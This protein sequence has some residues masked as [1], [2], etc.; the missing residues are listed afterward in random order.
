LGRS[1]T[2]NR[3]NYFI[4]R[5]YPICRCRNKQQGTSTTNFLSSCLGLAWFNPI[6]TTQGFSES[7]LN[8]SMLN[9]FE[10]IEATHQSVL[11]L[12]DSISVLLSTNNQSMI[13]LYLKH[14][15]Q[16]TTFSGRNIN[17]L[18]LI[19]LMPLFEKKVKFRTPVALRF[20]WIFRP[21]EFRV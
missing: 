4:R 9:I 14:S 21:F 5:Q 20:H 12:L 15:D 13:R 7:K 10:D 19:F 17:F 16:S 18:S 11:N 1:P 2:R 8:I 3:A 6:S